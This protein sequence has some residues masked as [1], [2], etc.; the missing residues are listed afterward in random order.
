MLVDPISFSIQFESIFQIGKY[1][2]RRGPAYS[3]HISSDSV[4][5]RSGFFGSN[6]NTSKLVRKKVYD[7]QLMFRY[8]NIFY[9][10]MN[11]GYT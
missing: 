11:I 10:T 8:F 1:L 9:K 5:D 4:F 3:T 7:G 2:D 6:A